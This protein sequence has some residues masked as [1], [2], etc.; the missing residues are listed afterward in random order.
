[1][2]AQFLTRFFSCNKEYVFYA[3]DGFWKVLA[4]Y[5]FL[6]QTFVLS[7]YFDYS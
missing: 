5:Q 2:T 3:D 6:M 4:K 1:M 7:V